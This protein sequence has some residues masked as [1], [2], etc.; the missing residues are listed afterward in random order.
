MDYTETNKAIISRAGAGQVILTTV[1]LAVLN[2]SGEWV[3]GGN[4]AVSPE[5]VVRL[6]DNSQQV[7]LMDLTEAIPDEVN[8]QASQVLTDEQ[9]AEAKTVIPFTLFIVDPNLEPGTA[10]KVIGKPWL[11]GT[12]VDVVVGLPLNGEPTDL[13]ETEA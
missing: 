3:L 8:E 12:V 10:E 13:P 9:A 1:G 11:G 4:K 2:D 6:I 7:T 5:D